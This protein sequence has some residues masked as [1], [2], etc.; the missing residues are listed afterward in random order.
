MRNTSPIQRSNLSATLPIC[1]YPLVDSFWRSKECPNC[2]RWAPKLGIIWSK[3]NYF[4]DTVDSLLPPPPYA[5]SLSKAVLFRTAAG[6]SYRK[7][8]LL[9]HGLIQLGKGGVLPGPIN[10]GLISGWSLAPDWKKRF[11]LTYIAVLTKTL[12]E[13][14]RFFKLQNVVKN[15]IH[16][17]KD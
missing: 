5:K 16:L 2:W 3:S 4:C 17:N 11:S 7:L 13:L 9:K 10:E 6:I 1:S 12:F 14:T 8:P 15:R